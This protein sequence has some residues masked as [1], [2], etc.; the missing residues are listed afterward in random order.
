[1][2]TNAPGERTQRIIQRLRAL[3][4]VSKGYSG[5][6]EPTSTLLAKLSAQRDELKASIVAAQSAT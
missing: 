4:I 5:N 3:S 2:K 6:S 1:M